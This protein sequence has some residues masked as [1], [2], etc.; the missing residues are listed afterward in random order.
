MY[1]KS[2]V[3]KGFKSFA[4]RSVLKLEPGMTVVVGPNGSGKS[5]ISDAVLWVLGEQSAKQLRGQAM[6]DVIFAGSSARQAVS[7]AEVDLVLDNSDGTLPLDFNEVVITRRMYRS[8]ESEYLIN[9]SPSRLMDVLDILNDSGLGRDTHS[10]IGQGS[11]QN[12][13]R[14]RP[15]DR[16]QLIEEAAGILKHKK[17][18]ERAARR[19]KNM[20][21]ELQRVHDIA[22][23]IDRQLRPLERQASKARQ[24]EQIT[25]ELRDVELSLAVDDLRI[26]QEQWGGT[27]KREKE[28]DAAV[29]LAKFRLDEKNRELEKYQRLL[30]EKGLFVGDLAEQRRRCQMTLERLDAGMLLL[31]E[32]G[33]NMVSR[34]S[35]L[36]QT[37][38]RS[39]GRQN[40]AIERHETL[41][42]DKR[43]STAK[44][45]ELEE[46]LDEQ[47]RLSKEVIES[48]KEADGR[49]SELAAK[50]RASE[51]ALDDVLLKT[52]KANE[53][54][55]T[56]HV[57]D[58]LLARR[59]EQLED[60]IAATQGTL[61]ARRAH[62]EELEG[63]LSSLQHD[64][65]RAKSDIDKRVRLHDD[66]RHALDAARD[67]YNDIVAEIGGLEEVDRAFDSASPF[68]SWT[69]EHADDIKG[70]VAPLNEIV[71]APPELEQL[72]EHLLGSDLRG[73]MMKDTKSATTL[74]TTLAQLEEQSGEIS[75]VP[76]QG[77]YSQ[78][79]ASSGERLLDLCSY[80]K[81]HAH[82]V[83]LL[84][85]DVYL[86]DS[87]EQAVK[88][89]VEAKSRV[90]FVTREGIV[91]WPGGKITVGNQAQDAEGVLSR[92][93]RLAALADERPAA[94]EKIDAAAKALE[95]A[96]EH[97]Q[98]AQNDDF[99]ISQNIAQVSGE[100]DSLRHEIGRLEQSITSS[101]QERAS[102][103]ERRRK[104]A[105]ETADSRAKTAELEEER[106]R[107]E[108]EKA[109][110]DEQLARAREERS[111]LFRRED[112][113]TR[114]ISTIQVELATVRERESHQE[115]ELESLERELGQL[116]KS[117]TVSK[118]TQESY[119]VLRLRVEPLHQTLSELRDNLMEKA[120]ML[121]DQ[122]Q[123]EQAGQ[124]DLRETIEAARSA[125]QH[126]QEQ[127]DAASEALTRVR[128]DKGQL[129]V[130][131]EQAIRIITEEHGVLLDIAL[132]IPAPEDREQSEQRAEK[133]RRRL[134]NLGSVN[135]VAVEEY[136]KL[137]ERRDF[138]GVQLDDLE[139][140][141]KA[142]K[143]IV[144]AIDRKMRN[145]F[146]ETFEQVN[147]NFEEVFSQ[148][149]PGGQG[150]LELTDPST[151]EETGVEVHAQP[152]GKAVRKQTLLS[153]GEQSLVALA[154]MFAVYRVRSTPF[155]ILDEVEAALDDTNLRRLL[156]YLDSIR[157]HTQFIIV[158]H[159]R[160]T[161]EMADL[162]YGVSMRSDGVSKLVS[163]KLDQAIRLAHADD[164]QTRDVEHFSGQDK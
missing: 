143:R 130:K 69:H 67:A 123:L 28:A 151:P 113:F 108:T 70:V 30:E 118:E 139:A 39:Q 138:I 150:H 19:L 97:L 33:R 27:E 133:L 164:G 11:L 38:H 14:A 110:F 161:M 58:D 5:N 140:A 51:K 80:D 93:R 145:R 116:Q 72:V 60:S 106:K 121:R 4:D 155:Y 100:I 45:V 91:V 64:S 76:Q 26:L 78:E 134:K 50:A 86:A 7:L 74:A 36:R 29:E 152:L 90:R 144:A 149:F 34:L 163:Q 56:V 107:L 85:G 62:L 9:G 46:Q 92:K 37:I 81:A 44:R 57:E 35:E 66:A 22:H 153:G 112:V 73:L 79:P 159:Q 25:G 61:G 6:E 87:L 83:E 129:E 65:T 99:E 131:V 122:A 59:A 17:R 128:I 18:K 12:V 148:L 32:K 154:L 13:L 156:S 48:R 101:Q 10:I 96:F 146:L 40:E 16:R 84:L 135:P 142:L 111:N 126:E 8:G 21:G 42:D 119:E 132:E 15:E 49:V 3:L 55:A 71:T 109:D 98:V 23:E 24:H 124:G 120:E 52:M 162:L 41:A 160:R 82:A 89:Q 47:R 117:L 94:Q 77:S 53:S 105:E 88:A 137:K 63:E 2:L 95:T 20:D 75:L 114:N 103:D 147:Q 125:V 31:E 141:D 104:I 158:S 127:V 54:L 136:R 102:I 1:L 115:R 68:L 43:A 157:D